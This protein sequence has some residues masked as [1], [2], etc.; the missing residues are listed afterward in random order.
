MQQKQYGSTALG[1]GRLCGAHEGDLQAKHT[2]ECNV[3]PSIGVGEMG[4]QR[5]ILQLHVLVSQSSHILNA[6]RIP[7]F[8]RVPQWTESLSGMCAEK[9]SCLLKTKI[10]PPE[11]KTLSK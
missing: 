2:T 8:C 4:R 1:E 5:L 3:C 9:R 6:C 7:S 11:I 10:H